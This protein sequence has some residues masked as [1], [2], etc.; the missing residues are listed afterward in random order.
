MAWGRERGRYLYGWIYNYSTRTSQPS[1][2]HSLLSTSLM[3]TLPPGPLPYTHSVSFSPAFS[4]IWSI[5]SL[6][7]VSSFF[8]LHTSQQTCG[9]ANEKDYRWQI[10]IIKEENYYKVYLPGSTRQQFIYLIFTYSTVTMCGT[11]L[12]H[13]IHG[14]IRAIFTFRNGLYYTLL[15]SITSEIT[16]LTIT[17]IKLLASN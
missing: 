17:W 9:S 5:H 11:E 1:C 6:S 2:S 7:P 12:L 15:I 3:H 10:W 14:L 16:C 8:P 4:C 13:C